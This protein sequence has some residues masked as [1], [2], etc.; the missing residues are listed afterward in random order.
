MRGHSGE[1]RQRQ[2][3]R[4]PGGAQHRAGAAGNA[5]KW[6]CK[7]PHGR[8]R[9][10]GVG[11]ERRGAGRQRAACKRAAG[12]LHLGEALQLVARIRIGLRP[13][14]HE[15]QVW[16][17]G[18]GRRRTAGSTAGRRGGRH[19]A[20]AQREARTADGNAERRR[21]HAQCTSKH[22]TVVQKE[23]RVQRVRVL[24]CSRQEGVVG[25]SSSRHPSMKP[26]ISCKFAGS[27]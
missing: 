3:G 24:R 7:R 15:V 11:R 9:A 13:L 22:S 10:R 4:P 12:S 25:G 6:R 16:G 17:T 23:A 21:I 27:S 8:R 14:V 5:G 26:R 20:G 1:A 2:A 19:T 18:P